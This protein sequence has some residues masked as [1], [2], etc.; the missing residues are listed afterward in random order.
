MWTE[1]ESKREE[2]KQNVGAVTVCMH[3]VWV[4]ALHAYNYELWAFGWYASSIIATFDSD[5][6]IQYWISTRTFLS[7]S[8]AQQQQK[9]HTCDIHF[10]PSDFGMMCDIFIIWL[11]IRMNSR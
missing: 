9:R 8:V 4:Y 5:W 10:V 7:I 2:T 6:I 3:R 1:E 11:A